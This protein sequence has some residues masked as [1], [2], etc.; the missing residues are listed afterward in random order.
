MTWNEFKKK[1]QNF[2]VGE[3]SDNIDT[4]DYAEGESQLNDK[5]KEI[6]DSYKPS[7]DPAK[8]YGDLSELLPEEIEYVYREYEGDD[9][10][11]IKNNTNQKYQDLLEADSKIVNDK[12]DVKVGE[13]EGKKQTANEETAIKSNALNDKYAELE[14]AIVNNLIQRGLFN[15]SIKSS[16]TQASQEAKQSELDSLSAD[17][18]KK[19]GT[20]DAQIDKL[21]GEE[22]VA[23]EQLDLSYAQKLE[24]EIQSLLDKRAKEIA[25][26]NDYNNKLKEKELQY[27]EDRT[28]AIEAQLAQRLKDEQAL[29]ALENKNGY[30]GE[31]EENY[32][33]RYNLAFDY[34]N[35]LPKNV[36]LKMIQENN[37]LQEYLGNY[38]GKLLA[39]ISK[40]N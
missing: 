36:A 40:K 21:R 16:Q 35:S 17:L 18:Q 3:S 37:Q 12:Y 6:A 39:N 2:F 8:G 33:Q 11:T 7:Y 20:Y 5:L 1:V 38:F 14:K 34:Y 30:A 24:S 13:V 23:L 29:K 28:K 31:K 26:I 22:N 9:E 10:E 25:S 15:S 27:I 19:L 4:S 32:T